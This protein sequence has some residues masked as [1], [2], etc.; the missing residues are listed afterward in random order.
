MFTRF[1][2]R[3]PNLKTPMKGKR[4]V[5]NGEIKEKSKKEL[6]AIPKTAIQKCFEDWRIRCHKCII[7]EGYYLEDSWDLGQ[8]S[9][10]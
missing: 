10:L 9:Y 1:G 2:L 7:S 4:F 6:F 8:D 5:M 3:F